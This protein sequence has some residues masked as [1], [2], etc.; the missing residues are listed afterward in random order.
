MLKVMS[1]AQEIEKAILSLSRAERDKLLKHIPELFPEFAGDSE[2]NRIIQDER[3]RAK[4]TSLL[5][6]YEADLSATPDAFPRIAETDFG[7]NK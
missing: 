6:Q 7:S 5:N 2:W 4:L 1:T 3:P